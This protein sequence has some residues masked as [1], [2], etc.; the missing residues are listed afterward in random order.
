FA[1]DG[2]TADQVRKR[3][4]PIVGRGSGTFSFVHID[5]VVASTIAA[6]DPGDRG[7]YN[8]VDDEPA[9]LRE[10][11]PV[12]AE[13]LGAKRPLRVPAW[14]AS[15]VAGKATVA[16]AIGLRGASNAKARRELGW[17]PA[18]ASWREGFKTA[19]G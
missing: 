16:M 14:L 5:D 9:P 4:Y 19:L 1:S 6:L 2:P 8:V 11:L 10:W 13:A 17:S 18:H 7:I 3:R 12:Y 15:L